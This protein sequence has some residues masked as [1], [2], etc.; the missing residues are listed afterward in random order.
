MG[1]IAASSPIKVIKE[2]CKSKDPSRVQEYI[3]IMTV[4]NGIFWSA[5]GIRIGDPFLMALNIPKTLL[6]FY[7][8]YWIYLIYRYIKCLPKFSALILSFISWCLV[9]VISL[10]IPIIADGILAVI[11]NFFSNSSPL[12]KLR[13]VWKTN[14]YML[15][16]I[17]ISI[18]LLT[19]QSFWIGYGIIQ[20]DIFLLIT[21]VY[22]FSVSLTCIVFNRCFKCV[23]NKKGINL[24]EQAKFAIQKEKGENNEEGEL[25]TKMSEVKTGNLHNYIYI[26][27]NKLYIETN[28]VCTS[29]IKLKMIAASKSYNISN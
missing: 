29:P 12:Q 8:F 21:N 19:V 13:R 9:V 24:E 3:F 5:Y 22:G 23:Y 27:I 6:Q 2:L 1:L 11:F 14:E 25:S 28:F 4:L 15:L 26:Y 18:S 17:E 7:I 10:L 20:M 16:P